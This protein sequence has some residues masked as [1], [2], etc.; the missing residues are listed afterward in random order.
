LAVKAFF[1]CWQSRQPLHFEGRFYRHTL[2]TPMFDPGPNETLPP[3]ILLGAVGPRMTR[4]AGEVADGLIVHPFHNQAFLRG[5]QLPDVL[6]ALAES[7][8]HREDF[9]FQVGAMCITGGTEE[10]LATARE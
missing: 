4:V 6:A 10:E 8:R 2:M 9:V 3:P 5:H 7:G 1:D